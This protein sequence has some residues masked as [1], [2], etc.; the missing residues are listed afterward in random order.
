MDR[1]FTRY[2]LK[3]RYP[4]YT[5]PT[6]KDTTKLPDILIDF[7]FE[8]MQLSTISSFTINQKVFAEFSLATHVHNQSDVFAISTRGRGSSGNSGY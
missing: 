8:Y 6:N 7:Y 3:Q 2:C 5:L 1:L 4:F